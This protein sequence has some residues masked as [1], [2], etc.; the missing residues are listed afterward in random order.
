[1][2]PYQNSSFSCSFLRCFGRNRVMFY[3]P[4]ATLERPIALHSDLKR[5]VSLTHCGSRPFCSSDIY[6]FLSAAVMRIKISLMVW[7]KKKASQWNKL[8]PTEQ[9]WKL[10]AWSVKT[11]EVAQSI[12]CGPVRGFRRI[13]TNVCEVFEDNMCCVMDRFDCEEINM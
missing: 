5:L 3:G 6:R 1:M 7:K 9:L 2:L 12:R 10:T 11:L 8:P 13:Y 4:R